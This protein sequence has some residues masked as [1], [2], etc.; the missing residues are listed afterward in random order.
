VPIPFALSGINVAL[1]ATYTFSAAAVLPPGAPAAPP[2]AAPGEIV[3]VTRSFLGG[4]V[5]NVPQQWAAAPGV[6][7]CAY[8]GR[9]LSVSLVANVLGETFEV[10][11]PNLAVTCTR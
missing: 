11:A 5:Y 3:G 10:P 7:A 8:C 1:D 4:T 2:A 9:V 6:D